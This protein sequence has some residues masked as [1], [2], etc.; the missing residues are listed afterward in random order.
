MGKS[1]DFYSKRRL[2]EIGCS[3]D[4]QSNIIDVC[5]R[6]SYSNQ[7]IKEVGDVQGRFLSNLPSHTLL[8]ALYSHCKSGISF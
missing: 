5:Y 3:G 1:F 2:P 8:A 6:C 4:G 7:D